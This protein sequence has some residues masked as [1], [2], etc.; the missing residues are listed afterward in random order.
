MTN[1]KRQAKNSPPRR[2]IWPDSLFVTLAIAAPLAD[3]MVVIADLWVVT[4]D[5]LA[6]Q[7]G[8]DLSILDQSLKVAIDGGETD[9]RELFAHPPVDLISEGMGRVTL[10][11][12]IHCFQLTRSSFVE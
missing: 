6:K 10:E 2:K 11:S 9:P 4:G 8:A 1:A 5:P 3:E 12:L 7:D